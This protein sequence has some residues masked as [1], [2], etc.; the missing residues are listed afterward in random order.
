VAQQPT[1][2]V[3]DAA[4]NGVVPNDEQDDAKALQVLIDRIPTDSPVQIQLP[5]GEIDL[6][7][8][9]QINRSDISLQGEGVAR[10]ILRSHLSSMQEA[11]LVVRSPVTQLGAQEITTEATPADELSHVQISSFSI[12]PASNLPSE[13][14]SQIDGILLENVAD[15][16][17]KHVSF[18]QEN[19]HVLVLNRTR[20][21][22]IEYVNFGDNRQP[23][24]IVLRD[25][26]NTQTKGFTLPAAAS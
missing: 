3:I 5:I 6:F 15:S 14:L 1:V 13:Q 19:R 22:A 20:D 26:R 10:T 16:M 12:R 11:V 7:Q 25:A 18:E 23:D 24:A 17:V 2:Q 8:S 21:I 9:I 4:A